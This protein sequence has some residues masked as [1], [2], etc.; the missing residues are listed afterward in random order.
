MFRV[1]NISNIQY[2]VEDLDAAVTFFTETL[3][4]YL[5]RRTHA[6]GPLSETG[7]ANERGEHIFVGLGDTWVE[8]LAPP[9][10]VDAAR[11]NRQRGRAN[12]VFA[13]AVENLDEMIEH[14]KDA[15]ISVSRVLEHPQSFWGRQVTIDPGPIGEPIALR[16]FEAPD[17]PRFMDWH[18]AK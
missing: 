6:D 10:Q 4:F 1:I 12:Y 18:P 3:G 14:L 17:G 15:G 8:L 16:E 9:N 5:Q 2:E 11:P 7:D 13:L